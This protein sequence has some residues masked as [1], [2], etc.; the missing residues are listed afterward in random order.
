[1]IRAVL[2]LPPGVSIELD[3]ER[4]GM[5][6]LSHDGRRVAFG[7]RQGAGPMRIWVQELET[8]AARPLPGTEEGY[9]PFWSPDDRRIGFFTWSHLATTPADGGAVAQLARARDA[10]GGSWNRDGTILF[11][12]HQYGPLL[13]D[14]GAGGE[15][16]PATALGDGDRSGTHR[17]PQFLPDGE[18]FLYLE[19]LSTFGPGQRAGLMLGRLGSLAPVARLLDGAT[20][21]VFAEGQILHT[22]DGALVARAFDP[23]TRTVADEAHTLVGDLLF[24]RRFSYGV[25]SAADR[26]VLAFLTGRQ[27]DRSQLVWRDRPGSAW[28]SSARRGSCRESAVSRSRA[29]AAGRRSRASRREPARP[30]SGSTTS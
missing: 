30:T 23:R 16:R 17:F 6:A 24:N 18:Q 14:L 25:F 20:N 2:P 8:G 3:G 28:G 29:T 19:R 1:M 13:R 22:R 15:A 5:P 12:P 11:A 27:R 7:A 4:A 10:R 26:G 9:R 21:A